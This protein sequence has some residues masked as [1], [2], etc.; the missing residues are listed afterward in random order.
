MAN[1]YN[2]YVLAEKPDIAIYY[3][4]GRAQHTPCP[5]LWHST[6][7]KIHREVWEYNIP[8]NVVVDVDE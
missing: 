7:P 4:A 3:L 8:E 1:A 5:T 6:V 2:L